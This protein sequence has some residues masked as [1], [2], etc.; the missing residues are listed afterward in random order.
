MMFCVRAG[1]RCHD[2]QLCFWSAI[3]FLQVVVLV[4]FLVSVMLCT[5]VGVKAFMLAG[6]QQVYMLG[7]QAVCTSTMETLRDFLGT[8]FVSEAV[9]PLDDVCPANKLMTCQLIRDRMRSP[10]ILTTAFSLLGAVLSL[11]MLIESA[12][13]HQQ[14]R[15]RRMYQ[16]KAAAQEEAAREGQ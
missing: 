15:Y 8:F 2:T 1:A 14:A 4:I 6:C 9:E 11:Q 13:L 10:V 16:E 12:V 7:D 3:I 5:L